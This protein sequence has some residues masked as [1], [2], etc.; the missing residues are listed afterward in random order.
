[1]LFVFA[2]SQCKESHRVV[3]NLYDLSRGSARQFLT[4]L[5]GKPIKGICLLG[6]DCN[7]FSNEVDQPLVGSTIPEYILQLPSEVSSSPVGRLVQSQNNV[8][9]G[10]S[11]ES[12]T[13]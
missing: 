13:G 11:P 9:I 1:M 3:L 6:H 5:L 12:S 2:T 4:T 10:G 7:N 8:K